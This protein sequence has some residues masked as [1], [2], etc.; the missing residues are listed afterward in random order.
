MNRKEPYSALNSS[1]RR[2]SAGGRRLK[3]GIIANELFS[4][5]VGR[6]GGFGWAARQVAGCF[7]NNPEL[8]VDPVLLMGERP[9]HASPPSTL[10]GARVLWLSDSLGAWVRSIRR[11]KIDVLLSI[12][13]RPNYAA[14]FA[15][16]PRTPVI[17]WVRDPRD[18]ADLRRIAT[19]RVP[20]DES[21][22]PQGILTPGTQSLSTV[23]ALSRLLGRS[24]HFAITTP[25]LLPKISNVYGVSRPAASVLPNIVP[26]CGSKVEKT[27]RP[28]IVFLGRLDP[29]KRPWLIFEIARR[30][31]ECDFF[32]MGKSHFEGP[33]SWQPDDVPGNVR[34]LGHTD[35][36]AK[37]RL[38][39][40]AWLLINTSIHDQLSRGA[41]P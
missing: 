21:A 8:T 18:T 32:V 36:E 4:A 3:V 26:P 35:T 29:V 37:Q 23:V 33:G 17:V 1:D 24:V 20:G 22:P 14:F 31:P 30:L 12:D 27:E 6:M 15:L 16:L 5:K 34:L 39:A 10:H 11:E 9:R 41:G 2:L 25:A 7:S 40:S 38:L 28:A 19:L 13:Y